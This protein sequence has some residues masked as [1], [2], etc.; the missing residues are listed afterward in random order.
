MRA[1]TRVATL[2]CA[3]NSRVFLVPQVQGAQWELGAAGNAEWTGVPLRALLERAELAEDVC[4][5]V[6][7]SATI[8]VICS[9][10]RTKKT[11]SASRRRNAGEG[12]AGLSNQHASRVRSP[13]FVFK[14]RERR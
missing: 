8:V 11:V 14:R 2:E 5:I 12:A 7:E 10:V 3:G 13:E 9:L 4:E 1:E 6:L